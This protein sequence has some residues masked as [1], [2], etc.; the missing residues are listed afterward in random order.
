MLA[1][2]EMYVQGVST[3]DAVKVMAA[4][5]GATSGSSPGNAGPQTLP[6]KSMANGAL[7]SRSL[8]TLV[9]LSS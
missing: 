3:R 1:I 9:L 7:A 4:N 6:G 8:K 5:P 2:A